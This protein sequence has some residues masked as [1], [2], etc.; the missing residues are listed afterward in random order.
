MRA[1]NLLPERHRPR[2]R[3]GHSNGSSYIVLGGLGAVLVAALVYVLT[4]NSINSSRD[5]LAKA[6]AD[7]ARFQAQAQQLGPY[8]DFSKIKTQRV[9]AVKQLAEGRF[10]W[11]RLVRE[12]SSV[13]PKGVW[14][15]NA[16]AADSLANAG[17]TQAGSGFN[18]DSKNSSSSGAA[19]N[20]GVPGPVVTIEGC[21]PDQTSVAT[22]LVR[23]RELDGAS[24]VHLDH[25]TQP[26]SAGGSSGGSSATGSGSADC[27][28]THGRD[29]WDFQ[30][31]VA[32][33][34]PK[35]APYQA[36]QVPAYLGGGQ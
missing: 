32:F 19:S 29:N 1:V 8:G 30:V 15:T 33:A 27:G 21:A 17:D 3:T 10:D 31:D 24:Q 5:E 11:E 20:P 34:A 26:N 16:A 18:Q 22:T 9:D 28:Q 23:L 4:L 36:G 6:K 13:L 35:P 12:L 7:T 2:T 14:L 25:S